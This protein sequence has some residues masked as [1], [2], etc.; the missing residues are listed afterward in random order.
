M[1]EISGGVWAAPPETPPEMPE[2]PEMPE[3]SGNISGMPEIFPAGA[4]QIS[5]GGRRPF[6]KILQ[7]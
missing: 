7:A 5:G 2:M 3:I 1:P 6:R 4:A